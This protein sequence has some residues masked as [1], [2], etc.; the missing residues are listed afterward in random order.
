M[1]LKSPSFPVGLA[2]NRT[3]AECRADRANNIRLPHSLPAKWDQTA[4]QIRATEPGNG[5]IAGSWGI[6]CRAD[7]RRDDYLFPREQSRAMKS[8]PWAGREEIEET[9][10]SAWINA[11]GWALFTAALIYMT[12]AGGHF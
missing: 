5:E 1:T 11:G 6:G 4:M 10:K 9:W 12:C 3:E 7:Y 8:R 2:G